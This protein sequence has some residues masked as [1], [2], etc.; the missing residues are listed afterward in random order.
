MG[1]FIM[2]ELEYL[3]IENR[4]AQPNAVNE[5]SWNFTASSKQQQEE[6]S[7]NIPADTACSVSR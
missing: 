4:Y 3:P 2:R 5:R 6:L 1:Y 7:K